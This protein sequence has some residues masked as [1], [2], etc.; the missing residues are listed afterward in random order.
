MVRRVKMRG[1]VT[2][3][4]IVAT[5]DMTA[6]TTKAQVDP[7]APDLEAFLAPARTGYD[8]LDRG[9]VGTRCHALSLADRL[10]IMV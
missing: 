5:T 4:R 1:R 9:A 3:R 7:S 6:R 2:M 8:L 10:A